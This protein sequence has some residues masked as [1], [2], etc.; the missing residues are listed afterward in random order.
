MCV[1]CVKGTD[2]DEVEGVGGKWVY[3]GKWYINTMGI[4]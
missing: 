4:G 2:T 1:P 3:D